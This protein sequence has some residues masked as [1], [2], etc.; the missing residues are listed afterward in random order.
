MYCKK[1]T[2]VVFTFN[3]EGRVERAV[4]N[5]RPYG[6]VLIVDNHSTDKTV[7]LACR[8]G[9]D[10]LRHKNR[11]WVED[12]VT[13]ARVKEAVS[14]PWLYWGFSDEILD[15]QTMM[16]ML[17]IIEAG[18]HSIVNIARK[19][20]YYGEFCH[21]AYCNTQ[22]RA[23]LKD[24]INFA[25]NRIHHFGTPTV[26][27]SAIATLDPKRH[28]VHHFISNTAKSY[29][30]SLDAY[31]DIEAIDSLTPSPCGT[32]LRVLRG[33]FGHYVLRGGRRA[34]RAGFYLGLQMVY[35]SVLLAMKAY[36]RDQDLTTTTIERHNNVVRD[37]LLRS[38]EQEEPMQ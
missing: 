4:R 26:D 7:E 38:L 10:V 24:A 27:D 22:N 28:F 32:A 29:L 1:I 18:Q 30:R 2:F 16:A 6:K 31:S 19:N 5:F 35:Y 17:E 23:F 14:T 9:A 25:G 36:E 37:R 12:D 11:G 15:Q 20:Y 34:G 21:E 8:L 33:F 3:E 13:V